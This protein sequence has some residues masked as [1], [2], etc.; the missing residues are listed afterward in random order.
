M[1]AFQD[2]TGQRFGRLVVVERRGST[3]NRA[4]KWFC[5]CDCGNSKVICQRELKTGE[6][7]SCGCLHKELLSSRMRTHGMSKTYTYKI[8]QGIIKRCKNSNA[9]NF[10]YYGGRGIT[11]CDRWLESFANFFEDMGEC[12]KGMSIDRIDSSGNYEPENCRWAT[13]EQ[14]AS[15]TR[16]S[17]LIEFDGKTLTLSQWS[18]ETEL[19]ITTLFYRFERGWSIEKALTLPA[20]VKATEPVPVSLN[21]EYP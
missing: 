5:E 3:K 2:L 8:W 12:P 10:D 9:S 4:A 21:N 13:L 20:R 14:Q 6:S 16:R 15:N 7:R 11:V 18:R 1:P 19:G 17:R